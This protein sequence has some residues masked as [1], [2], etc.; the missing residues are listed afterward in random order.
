MFVLDAHAANRCGKLLTAIKDDAVWLLDF[1]TAQVCEE[2]G[3]KY[4]HFPRAL[5][6]WVA[7]VHLYCLCAEVP[8]IG[9]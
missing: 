7:E 1:H 5:K 4:E 3:Q 2:K 9:L 6:A 8:L